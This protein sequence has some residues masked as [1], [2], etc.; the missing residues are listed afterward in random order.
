MIVVRVTGGL[1]NQMFQYAF[2]RTLQTRGR[3]VVIQWHG[4]RTK[5]QHNG[6]ELNSVFATP[7]STRIR[8]ANE[9]PLLNAIAWFKRRTAREREPKSNGFCAECLDA[10]RGY[11]DGY[12]QSEKY[13]LE[14]ED[15]IR[16]DFRF[17][18]LTGENNEQLVAR[19]QSEPC[20]SVH[21]RRGDYCDIPGM[22][23]I[24]PPDYYKQ[25]LATLD[26]QEPG[27]TPIVFSDDIP[28]CRELFAGRDAVFVNWNQKEKSWMDMAL[29]GRCKHHIIAN[30]SFSWWGAWLAPNRDGL[31]IAPQRWS[32]S[33]N[34]NAKANICPESWFRIE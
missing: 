21:V 25:A 6:W 28:F 8:V 19:I 2:A 15:I 12:W 27:C 23:E 33:E 18:P 29:M 24:C 5:S 34:N 11:L 7:L 31:I 32:P 16:S 20:V 1:G 22:S 9:S 10:T 26:A 17:G 13:F 4:H 14:I 30:S 3:K